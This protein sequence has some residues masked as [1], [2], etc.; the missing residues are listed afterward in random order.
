MHKIT[1]S[2]KITALISIL[3][4]LISASSSFAAKKKSKAKKEEEPAAL[5]NWAHEITASDHEG[6]Q[7]IKLRA[8]YY[9]NEYVEQLIAN[10]A[11]SSPA[12]L[13]F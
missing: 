5:K 7:E 1:F 3:I 2:K 10:E 8:T 11:E 9:S 4:I 13:I 12:L 6:T